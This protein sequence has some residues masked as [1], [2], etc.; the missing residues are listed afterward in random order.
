M[1]VNMAP[2][3]VAPM[4][5]ASKSSN[6]DLSTDVSAR[7][8][9]ISVE[10]EEVPSRQPDEPAETEQASPYADSEPTMSQS[11][12]GGLMLTQRWHVHRR[13][14]S[15]FLERRS[16]KPPATHVHDV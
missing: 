4:E 14:L 11:H 16:R 13:H 8:D 15:Q 9:E 10:E 12:A 6:G 7:I 2:V 5:A 3:F 1:F